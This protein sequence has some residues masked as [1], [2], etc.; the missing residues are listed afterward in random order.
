VNLGEQL[1]AELG[2]DRPQVGRLTHKGGPVDTRQGGKPVAVV[3]AE[4]FVAALVG[5]D[6][7]ELADA[8]DG[9]DFAVGQHRLGPR[10][11]TRRPASQ[12]SIRQYTEMSSVVASM[13]RP[14]YAW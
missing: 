11:R 4:V 9:Q 2:L 13:A 3:A 1:L 6:A 14:P 10:C 12:S 7:Q 8:F 5:V